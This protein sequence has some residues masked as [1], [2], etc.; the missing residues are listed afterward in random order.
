[1]LYRY[2][3][4]YPASNLVPLDPKLKAAIAAM[5]PR[6]MSLPIEQLR[7]GVEEMAATQPKLNEAVGAVVNRKIPG[8]GGDI[9]IRIYTPLGKPPFPLLIH[10]HG[11]G[12]VWGSL[13]SADDVCR[14]L[15]NRAGTAIVSVDYRL[16]PENKFP[17]AVDDGYAALQWVVE[18]AAA[19]GGNPRAVAIGGDSSGGNIA[20]AVALYS[21]DHGGPKA[22]LQV[23]IYPVTNCAFDTASYH[24][25][26]GGYGLTREAMMYFWF[27]YL[28]TPA[29]GQSPYASP[30]QAKDLSGLP[31]ALI[32][33]AQYDPLRDDGEAYAARLHRSGVPVRLTR[34]LD[35]NHAFFLYGAVYNSANRVLT[36]IAETL[37]AAFRQPSEAGTFHW[38]TTL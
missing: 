9:P 8:P 31:P 24:E 19:L 20:T 16:A 29:D 38:P 17:A 33:T 22:A 26:A 14:S 32:V 30:L 18:N 13:D 4:T 25:N 2:L 7:A 34:Y 37:K 6:D 1:V 10:I 23:L 28:R 11:G 35:M 27:T 3:Q 21:R 15:C 12:W 36:E 5:P